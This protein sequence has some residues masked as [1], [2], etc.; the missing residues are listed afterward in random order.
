MFRQLS[1][2]A[3]LNNLTSPSVPRSVRLAHRAVVFTENG[4]PAS[5]LKTVT[6]PT[7]PAPPRDNVNV[8][9][10]ISPIN[11]SDI[12]VIE[13]V[14]PS[15]P[16]PSDS[17]SPG[18]K[19]HQPVYVPGNEGLA[20]I[21]EVG[22]NV[23][24]L[25]KGDWVVLAKQQPGTWS[26]ARTISVEDVVKL[27]VDLS[28]VNAATITVNPPTAYN[29]LRTFVDLKEGDWVVQNGAN[30]AVGQAIIQISASRGVKTINFIRSRPD[31][32]NL[33]KQLTELGATR[34]YT[35]DDLSDKS[36]YKSVK[37]LTGDNPPRLLL[38]CVSGPATAQMTR[39]LGNNAHVV[40]YGAMSKKP[41]TL[42]TGAMIF[43]G[44]TAHGFWVTKWY[45]THSREER[46]ALFAEIAKL[47]LR[48]PEHETVVLSSS[49][50]DEEA[51]EKVREIVRKIGEGKYGK[52]VLLKIED[53]ED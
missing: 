13:G 21:T 22:E 41:L 3:N 4:D 20:E 53:P 8:R 2:H 30:S 29:M 38:N 33:K 45:T 34:V 16:A 32:E 48:E 47:K 24:G 15:K 28:E 46:E 11:P 12:N 39:L 10:R 52:K 37:E 23:K 1:R 9:F 25:K 18:H 35:Y 36:F 14:Y 7:L 50:T 51:G 31:T 27:P 40:S 6:Y 26:S 42:P 17:L 43:K 49:L 19:L 44:L 5:V